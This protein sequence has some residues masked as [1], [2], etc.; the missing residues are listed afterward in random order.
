MERVLGAASPQRGPHE[1]VSLVG[2]DGTPDILIARTARD[3]GRA[4][5]DGLAAAL[6]LPYQELVAPY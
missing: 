4:L 6:K 3:A 2:K 1:R 5:G